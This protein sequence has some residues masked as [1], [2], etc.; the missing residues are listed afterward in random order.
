MREAKCI[1]HHLSQMGGLDEDLSKEGN[2]VN[3]WSCPWH[4]FQVGG[5]LATVF[6]IIIYFG[7]LVPALPTHWQTAAYVVSFLAY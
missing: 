2:R 3:G 4:I 7:V 5:W 6:F 1:F